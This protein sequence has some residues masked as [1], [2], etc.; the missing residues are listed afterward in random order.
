MEGVMEKL[1]INQHLKLQEMCDCY[2]ETDFVAELEHMAEVPTSVDLEE[3]AMKYLALA[4]MHSITEQAAKLSLKK[5]DDSIIVAVKDKKKEILP[6]PTDS[7]FD[8]II[9]IVRAILHIEEDKGKLPLSLGLRNGE[10]NFIVK[11]KRDGSKNSATFT[12]AQ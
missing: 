1:T 7:I 9:E 8:K 10:V 12:V 11:V 2:L 6:P 3:E 5:K 4:I